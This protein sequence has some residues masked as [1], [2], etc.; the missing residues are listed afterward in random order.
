VT[1]PSSAA[2]LVEAARSLLRAQGDGDIHTVAAAVLDEHDR[3][4]VGLNL[5]HFTG[6]PCAEL[7]PGGRPCRRGQSATSHRCR[8]R[9]R[10]GCP[11]SL[12]TRPAGV[13][14]L[15]GA[16]DVLPGLLDYS[17]QLQP[18]SEIVIVRFEVDKS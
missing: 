17:P 12:W 8:R 4:H 10:P 9:R 6:G 1:L 15:T 5:Y 14:R 16:A 13:R 7:S 2:D 3:I 18:T 11:G